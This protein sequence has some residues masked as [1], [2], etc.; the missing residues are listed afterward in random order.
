[1]RRFAGC[2]VRA[3]S[4]GHE[5]G[6]LIPDQPGERWPND[7]WTIS[8]PV[9]AKAHPEVHLRWLFDFILPH[10]PAVNRWREAG[11][12][13]D[14]FL[15]YGWT[16]DHNDFSLSPQAMKALAHLGIPWVVSVAG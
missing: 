6:D 7:I 14:I 3:P 15:S 11:A 8:A 13:M 10:L 5:K 9:P 4:A 12:R 1:M 16:A 2:S